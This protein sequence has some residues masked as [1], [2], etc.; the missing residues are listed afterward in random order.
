MVWVVGMGHEE[1]SVGSERDRIIPMLGLPLDLTMG[2]VANAD[3]FV[4]IDSSMLHAADLARVPGVGLFGPTRAAIWGFRF[5]P[6]RHVEM[7]SMAEITAVEV[8]GAL[9]DLVGEH[10]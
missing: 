8:L 2:L 6:H 9:E 7:S 3:V 5:A 1:L 10:V 4:G